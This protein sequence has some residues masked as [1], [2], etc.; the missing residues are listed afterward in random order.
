M[1][2]ALAGKEASPVQSN[3]VQHSGGQY[4][5]VQSSAA[6]QYSA[7]QYSA[8]E[9]GENPTSTQNAAMLRR[10]EKERSKRTENQCRAEQSDPK[11]IQNVAR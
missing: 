7:A 5:P 10:S 8:V 6:V 2:A 9:Y 1:A 3:P 11:A 4:N